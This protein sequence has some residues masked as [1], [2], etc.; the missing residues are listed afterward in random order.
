MPS[1]DPGL[2]Q[3]IGDHAMQ[4]EQAPWRGSRSLTSRTE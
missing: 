1:G 2:C 4:T 3:G